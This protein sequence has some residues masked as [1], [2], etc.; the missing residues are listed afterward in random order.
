MAKQKSGTSQSKPPGISPT[1]PPA[2]STTALQPPPDC[3]ADVEVL[4]R[5]TW[6][7]LHTLSANYPERPSPAHQSS[8]SQFLTLFGKMYPCGVCAEDFREWMAQKGNEP[9]LG[10]RDE[11]GTWLCRAHNAVNEKLGKESFDC[12]R[13]EERWR[14]GWK[15]GRC[16]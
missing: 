13:W 15:D 10:T 5:S 12:S 9:K 7:F 8:T 14:T 11:F 1:A 2:E 3:P 4:G 6:T 16:D